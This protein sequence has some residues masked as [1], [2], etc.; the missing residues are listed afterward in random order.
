MKETGSSSLE[1][2]DLL[3]IT[4]IYKTGDFPSPSGTLEE[5]SSSSATPEDYR[6]NRGAS[7][8]LRGWQIRD[9]SDKAQVLVH[10]EELEKKRSQLTAKPT[11]PSP[12]RKLSDFF[13][14]QFCQSD[15]VLSPLM[16]NREVKRDREVEYVSNLDNPNGMLTERDLQRSIHDFVATDKYHVSLKL[17]QI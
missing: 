12:F 7:M 16:D 11:R 9:T 15:T 1:P 4:G 2:R 13:Q 8:Y 3:L 6:P 14:K 17:N 10:A 5:W